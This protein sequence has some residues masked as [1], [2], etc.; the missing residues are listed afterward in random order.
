VEI[1]FLKKKIKI[2]STRIDQTTLELRVES[3]PKLINP[4]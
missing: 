4:G 3:T 2:K 1:G